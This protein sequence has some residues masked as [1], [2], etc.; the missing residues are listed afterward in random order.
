MSFEISDFQ[1][2]VLDASA[3]VPVLVDFW[4][5]WC[6][7]C[8]IIG[9]VLEKLAGESGGQW[10]LA[11]VNVDEHQD[12]A[13][14]FRIQSI[15]AVKL[16]HRGQV[17]QEFV[18]ALPERAVR[19]WLAKALPSESRDLFEQA[20]TKLETGG[21]AEARAMLES[22]VA[23]DDMMDA[24]AVL[25]K[26]I[27]LDDPDRARTLVQGAEEGTLAGD[28]ANDVREMADLLSAPDTAYPDHRV[29]D[30]FL[31]GRRSLRQRRFDEA[32][33]AFIDVV[34]RDK[35]YHDGAAR[36]ACIAIFHFLGDTHPVTEAWRPKFT[37]AL[38]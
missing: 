7:P 38:Y 29:R 2:D 11:K 8:R 25:A 30:R 1:K 12:V 34:G 15:P 19:D 21:I 13:A 5:P 35:T 36:K 22:I 14:T 28:T 16:F 37:M 31:E 24:R 23:K 17:I 18:G 27:V 10:R 20:L 3:R 33:S 4:A 26:I 32:L 9:P 6:G